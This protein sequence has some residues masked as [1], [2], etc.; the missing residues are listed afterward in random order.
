M[1]MVAIYDVSLLHPLQ[2]LPSLITVPK[3]LPKLRRHGVTKSIQPSMLG[4]MNS[5]KGAK[6]QDESE[7]P[8]AFKI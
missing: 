4:I 2:G 6:P 1:S 7:Y 3:P 5:G 8:I